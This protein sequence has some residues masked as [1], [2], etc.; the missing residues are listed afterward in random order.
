M[1]TFDETLAKKTVFSL[2]SEQATNTWFC[3]RE[4]HQELLLSFLP[5][6]ASVSC[7]CF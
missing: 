6:L 3:S 4:L 7:R 1:N 5:G 2:S